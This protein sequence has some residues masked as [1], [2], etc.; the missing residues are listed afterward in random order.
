[1]KLDDEIIEIKEW[2]AVR[3]PPARGEATKPA[4]T[5]SS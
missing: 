2:D 4:P 3:V 1:M 5:A